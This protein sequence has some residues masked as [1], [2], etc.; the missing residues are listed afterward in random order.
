MQVPPTSQIRLRFS[1]AWAGVLLW[2]FLSSLLWTRAPGADEAGNY[3][4]AVDHSGSM[5]MK[6]GSGPDSGKSRWEVLRDRASGFA[7]RLP[8]GSHVWAGVFSARD[9]QDGEVTGDPY[10]GWLTPLSARFDSPG[11]RS[12]FVTR[13]KAFPEPGLANGTWLNQAMMESLLKAE[14]AGQNDP[15]AYLTVMVY[16]DGVDQGHGRTTAEMIRNKGSI[17]TRAEVDDKVRSLRTRHR[18]FNLVHVYRPGDESILDAHVVRLITNR[19]QLASPLVSPEQTVDIELR[20]KDD[21]RLKLEGKPLNVSWQEAGPD[22]APAMEIAGGPFTMTNGKVRINLR[23]KGDWP[24]GRDVRG[25]L[26]LSYPVIQDTFLV[27]EGGSTVDVLFQGAEAPGIHDL[28]PADGS[29][30]PVGRKISFSLSTLPG[31]EVEWHFGDG[32]QGK[33]NPAVHA[34]DEPGTK[35]VLVKVSD[36]RTGLSATARSKVTLAEL[37]LTLDPMPNQVVPGAEI[38]LTATATG[39]FREFFWDIGGRTYAG[40]T[41]TDGIAGS[42]LKVAFDRPGP[43]SVRAMGDGDGGGRAETET[44]TLVIK[45]VPAIRLSSP[46]PGEVLYFESSRE[47]RAEVEGVDAN[48][49]RFT[50]KADGKEL[51]PETVV[52]VR[53]EDTLRSAVLP[54]QIPR[55]AQR[56]SA[57]LKV[58]TVGVTPPLQREIE[59]RLESE[60]A[61]IQIVL[62]EGREPHISRETS[63]RLEANAKVSKIRWNFG[64]GWQDGSEIERPVWNQYGTYEIKATATAPDGSELAAVPVEIEIPVRPARATA[65]VIYKGRRVGAEVAK[66]PVNATL[67]LRAETQ[68]DVIATRWLLDGMELPAGQET[69][70]VQNRG[71]KTIQFIVDATPEAGGAAA[72]KASIEFRTSDKILFWAFTAAA[73]AILAVA[74]RLL[75]GNKWRFARFDVAKTANGTSY[76]NGR[77]DYNIPWTLRS[78]W[79]KKALIKLLDLDLNTSSSWNPD[80][81]L[82]FNCKKEP[83][84]VAQG[85]NAQRLQKTIQSKRTNEVANLY[86]RQWT[87]TRLNMPPNHKHLHGMISIRLAQ[88]KPG[89]IGRWPEM[90]FF[91]LCVVAVGLFRQLHELFY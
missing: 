71:F 15:D 37:K 34:Y 47:F 21:E 80:T 13:L 32:S 46:A 77:A 88:G 50:L 31:C 18:N 62:P 66:V 73:L 12:T 23:K 14:A 5:L 58:E 89:I 65:A 7:E 43:V 55:L 84:L 52:D 81:F 20:F 26:K 24:V 2:A 25:R 8:D 29:L 56:T 49:L 59:V 90:L 79:S 67:E 10:A 45:E 69:V 57:L 36:P 78:W 51:L 1:S 9:P 22:A 76:S 41:R 75:L 35:E 60:P 16:T 40:R 30:F 6:V 38:R 28:L 87:F 53:R 44:A 27:E 4:L 19:V 85:R 83:K 86:L 63:V 74:A 70:T 91:A 72:T 61:S 17:C 33:G 54:C 3:F 48:Q 68:G 42:E 64:S 82:M 11:A 39:S